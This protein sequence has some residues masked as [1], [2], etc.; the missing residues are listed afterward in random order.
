MINR[1]ARAFAKA[2]YGVLILDLYGTGDSEGSFGEANLIRWQQDILAA[3]NWLA[4]SSDQPPIIWAMRSGALI[5]ADLI[6]QQP[7]LTDQM[8]LWSP[9]NNGK[10]FISQYLRIKLAAEVTSQSAVPKTT[11]K[12]LWAGLDA[13]QSLEIAGYELSPDLANGF[14]ALSLAD[15]TLPAGLSVKWLE[16][17]LSDPARLSPAS[18]KVIEKWRGSGLDVTDQAI[19]DI[20]FWTL[21][22]PEWAE[23]YIEQ[24]LR[25]IEA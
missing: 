20:A 12:D 15:I 14:A 9:V 22:E 19:N 1:Q 6:Q 3:V 16:T 21:Q 2:G 17:S 23:T 10:K 7:D 5:A 13:G 11:L 8:I 4:E 25:L 24:T 18:H